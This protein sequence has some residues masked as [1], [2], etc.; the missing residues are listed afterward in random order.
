M[1]ELAPVP[2]ARRLELPLLLVQ[3]GRDYQVPT[4]EFEEWKKELGGRDNVDF[5]LF[6]DL[7][8]LLI[9]GS[10]PSTP[11]EY[12]KPGHVAEEVIEAIARFVGKSE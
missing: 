4:A 8:H 5:E 2:I 10:G 9:S 12:E 6:P 11:Q 7:N 1:R 3:G